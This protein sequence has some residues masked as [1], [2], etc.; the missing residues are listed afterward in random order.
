MNKSVAVMMYKCCVY[1]NLFVLLLMIGCCA[2]AV[3]PGELIISS[4]ISSIFFILAFLGKRPT[5]KL[6]FHYCHILQQI[7]TAPRGYAI[8]VPQL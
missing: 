7:C 6:L 2:G 5:K 3:L 8:G 1:S 4:S